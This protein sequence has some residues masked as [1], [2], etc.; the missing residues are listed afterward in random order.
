VPL[1]FSRRLKCSRISAS[2][3]LG[4]PQP[5]MTLPG[6]SSHSQKKGS[7]CERLTCEVL[8]RCTTSRST[9]SGLHVAP[10]PQ[11]RDLSAAVI[12]SS[13]V[14][15]VVRLASRQS[16]GTTRF[17]CTSDFQITVTFWF[18]QEFPS[19]LDKFPSFPYSGMLQSQSS[20][21]FIP[22]PDR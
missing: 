19:H 8:H 20:L 17:I 12:H 16:A 4:E 2:K 14:Q 18:E 21:I 9:L 3:N 10:V 15:R 11:L 22:P 6:S 13:F 5:H 7:P 1:R